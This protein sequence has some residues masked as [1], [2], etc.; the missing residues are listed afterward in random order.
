MGM[1]SPQV[2]P[3]QLPQSPL[4]I[5]YQ[6]PQH[7]QPQGYTSGHQGPMMKS[8]P[9][10]GTQP[11]YG[12]T[13]YGGTQTQQSMVPRQQYPVEIRHLEVCI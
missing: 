13:Q 1:S 11:Q 2:P 7:L 8:S 10:G 12:G 9:Y 5:P 6:S 3:I 4:Q